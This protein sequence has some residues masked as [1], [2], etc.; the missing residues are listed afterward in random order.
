MRTKGILFQFIFSTLALTCAAQEWQ[1]M[2]HIGGHGIDA[3]RIQAEDEEGNL[4]ALVAYAHE[5]Q[6]NIN[7]IQFNDCYID[8]D[9]IQGRADALIVKYDPSGNII[10]L[11]NCLSPSGGIGFGKLVVDTV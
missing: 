11:K 3:A 5:V 9:T 10:W 2:K 7:P 4:Y 6:G 1:W 8:G